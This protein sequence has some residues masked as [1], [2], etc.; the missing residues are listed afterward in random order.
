M[1]QFLAIAVYRCLVAGKPSGSL[2][3]SVRFFEAESE[4][5]VRK[6]LSH[7]VRETYENPDGEQVAWEL[8]QVMAVEEFAGPE[9]GDEVVGFIAE[10]DEFGKLA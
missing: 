7:D 10:V 6:K 1:K 9:S 3:V 2:D 5:E 4:M 8:R